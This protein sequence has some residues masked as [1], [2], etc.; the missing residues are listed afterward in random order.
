MKNDKRDIMK[1]VAV[2]VFATILTGVLTAVAS[3]Y[4]DIGKLKIKELTLREKVND[5]HSDVKD[6]K[7]FLIEENGVNI[8][9][10]K[11]R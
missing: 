5:I 2:A 1:P 4:T 9:K 10:K 3:M 6:I 11:T 8:N 7:W